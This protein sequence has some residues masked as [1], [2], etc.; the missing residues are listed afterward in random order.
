MRRILVLLA[1]VVL[2]IGMLTPASANRGQ[3]AAHETADVVGQGPGGEVMEG[4]EATLRRTD[5]AIQAKVKMPTPKPGEYILP[6][7]DEND[8]VAEHGHPEGF[9][10]WLFVFDEELG[11]FQDHPW[12]SA[13][14]VAGHMVGGEHLT[15]SGQIDDNTEGFG[16]P[17]ENPRDVEVHLAVAPHGG[18]DPD[19][20][21]ERIKTPAGAPPM[22]W[23]AV[24]E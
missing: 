18:L 6:D 23:F 8:S 4:A 10:L 15:L 7:P 14:F 19:I 16:Y 11:G 1:A 21:P 3:G 24:F 13:F 12:S 2:L 17:L 20:M 5:N 9:S 22:W